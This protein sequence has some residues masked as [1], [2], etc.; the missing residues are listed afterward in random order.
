MSEKNAYRLINPH[1]EGSLD[2]VVRARNSYTAGKKIYGTISNYFTNPVDDFYMSIQNVETKDLTHFRIGEKRDANGFVDFELV[3]LD[4]KFNPDLEKK[5]INNVE[6]ISKQ[7]GGK[8]H[9]HHKHH[10]DHINNK[11]E[12]YDE[13]SSESSSSEEDYYRYA[14]QPITRFTYFYL[15]YYKLN[16]IGLSPLD[17]SRIF[18]PMFNLPINPSLEI[19]FDLYTLTNTY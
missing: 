3:R 14:N 6:K 10:K 18:L 17:S 19:R 7:Y 5:L 15:P 13:S 9:K 12:D 8:H 2:T 16:T 4:N 1:I 11:D